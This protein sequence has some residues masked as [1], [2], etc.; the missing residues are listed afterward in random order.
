MRRNR[1]WAATA[2]SIF[3]LLVSAYGASKP[4][5]LQIYFI[6]VEGGQATLLVTPSRQSVLIDTGWAGSRDA[7]RILAAAKAAKVKR[8]DYVLI[9][10]YHPDHVGGVADLEKRI[11]IGIFVDHGPD[12]EDSDTAR[13]LYKGYEKAVEHSKRIHLMPGEGLPIGAVTFEVVAAAGQHI[14]DPLPGAG[15]ANFYCASET[16]A[17]ADPS[18]NA[19]SI[20]VLVSYGKFRFLDLG[21]LTKKKE[22]ELVCPNNLIGTISL[23]LLTHHGM[24]PDNPKALSWALHPQVAVSN[25]GAHKGGDAEVWQIVH[26]SPSLKDL[27]QLHYAI[28]AGKE[29]N[30]PEN[31]IANVDENS[32]GHY[33]KVEAER[34]GSLVV[35]NSRNRFSRRYAAGQD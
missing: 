20:G 13:T 17:K 34:D 7:D 18:E 15:E 32:D 25:N 14:S 21:D 33:I 30:V 4:K 27:W 23:Y 26:D 29:H 11:P 8:I 16:E 5:P 3:A 28:D 6:D 9:T 31:F 24:A 19:Q 2:L 1:K 12:V 22:L 10:H 35:T